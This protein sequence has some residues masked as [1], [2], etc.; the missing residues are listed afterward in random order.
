MSL[1]IIS[2]GAWFSRLDVLLGNLTALLLLCIL[3]LLITFV[4]SRQWQVNNQMVIQES[5]LLSTQDPITGSADT[6]GLS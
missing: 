2:V 5:Y 4:S 3:S 6:P 1:T